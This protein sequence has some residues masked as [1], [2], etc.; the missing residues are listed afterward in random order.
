[1]LYEHGFGSFLLSLPKRESENVGK[2]PI[3]LLGLGGGTGRGKP[4]G[5]LLV[6]ILLYL[7]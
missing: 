3:S 1:V 5:T 7:I 2:H 4:P 6:D